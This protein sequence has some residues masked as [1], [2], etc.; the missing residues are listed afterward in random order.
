[1]AKDRGQ[2]AHRARWTTTRWPTIVSDDWGARTRLHGRELAS[3]WGEWL[4]RIPWEFFITL[5][6]DPKRV[7]PVSRD[8]AAREA[9]WW[10]GVAAHL[11]R[12]PLV[13]AYAVERGASGHWHAHAVIADAGEPDWS[14]LEGV[15][16]M[17][18]GLAVAKPVHSV[19]GVALYTTKSAT[20]GEVVI[21]DTVDLRRFKALASGIVVPLAR[22]AK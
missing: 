12:R 18:N 16:Q 10:L 7:F 14:T 20:D 9:F 2:Q 4:G 17:R 21:S 22:E 6:F 11:C 19:P 13:W 8:V 3:A 5:T 15:W 1:M